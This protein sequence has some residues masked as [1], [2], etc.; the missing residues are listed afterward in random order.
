M[1]VFLGMLAAFGVGYIIGFISRELQV[2]VYYKAVSM[3][4]QREMAK[5]EAYD[6]AVERADKEL[7]KDLPDADAVEEDVPEQEDK[8]EE[9]RRRGAKTF[10]S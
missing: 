7:M 6:K 3:K 2:L 8:D 9:E 10:Y 1:S 4:A 5:D